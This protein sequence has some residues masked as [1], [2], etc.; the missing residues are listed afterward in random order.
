MKRFQ[1]ISAFLMALVLIVSLLPA[2]VL[3]AIA[4]D[5]QQNGIVTPSVGDGKT[6]LHAVYVCNGV[7][8][9]GGHDHTYP[10]NVAL[11]ST[12]KLGAAW[13]VEHLYLTVNSE[14]PGFTKLQ[15]NG[16]DVVTKMVTDPGC[17]EY[18]ISLADA[19]I[20]SLA[21]GVNKV[22]VQIGE[23]AVQTLYLIFENNNYERQKLNSFAANTGLT[24]SIPQAVLLQTRLPPAFPV[25]R[26]FSA[27]PLRQL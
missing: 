2:G 4:L 3:P 7:T 8:L 10:L 16:V 18:K 17:T 11:S 9:G 20:T 19:G 22:T 12:M 23:Q 24:R 1:R 5:A 26:S 27:A 15:V 25:R 6:Y 14:A 21:S 13:D